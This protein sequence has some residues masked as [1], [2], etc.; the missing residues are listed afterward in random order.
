MRLVTAPVSM[1]WAASAM[2]SAV[3]GEVGGDEDGGG[4][5]QDDVAAGAV[6]AGEDGA[7]DGGVGVGVATAQG[8]E[9]SAL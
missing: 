2:P 3:G 6:L 9:G 1:A 8:F 7:E 5:E 4:V